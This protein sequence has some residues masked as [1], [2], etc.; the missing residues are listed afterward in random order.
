MEPETIELKLTMKRASWQVTRKI[1]VQRQTEGA[2]DRRAVARDD[3]F[4]GAEH[5]DRSCVRMPLGGSFDY[6]ANAL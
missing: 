6:K 4:A 5:V 2:A 1:G 3:R